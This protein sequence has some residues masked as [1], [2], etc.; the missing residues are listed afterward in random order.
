M[1]V[2]VAC[3]QMN[4]GNDSGRNLEQAER[5]VREAASRGAQLIALPENMALMEPEWEKMREAARVEAEHQATVWGGTL[6][7]ELGV[8]LLLGSLQITPE[9]PDESGRYHNRSLVISPQGAVS[10]RYNKI[11]LFDVEIGAADSSGG[12]YRE[13]SRVVAGTEA[14]VV[15]TPLA[16]LGLTVCYDVRFPNL[17][18]SLALAGAEIV[19]VPAAFTRVT[20]EAHWHTLL[21]A[22]AIETGCFILA[23]AQCG[24]HPGKRQTYGHSLIIDPWGRI[25][26]EAGEEPGVIMAE[27]DLSEVAQ[28]RK[29]I[30]NLQHGRLM[31]EVKR[32]KSTESF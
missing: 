1:G 21:R 27:L 32:F 13:S 22:R 19:M 18:Q 7:R 20:G 31:G 6:A 30:P 14:V 24:E 15:E 12:N 10:G 3:G 17:F 23:P 26:A 4:S 25:L 8:W 28:S 2:K 5:L 9:E 16:R 29:K 11:H